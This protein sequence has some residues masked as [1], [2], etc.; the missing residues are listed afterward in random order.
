MFEYG[1]SKW[2]I[3]Y[4][5]SPIATEQIERHKLYEAGGI[6]DIWICGVQNYGTGNKHMEKIMDG[7]FSSKD[8]KFI[9]IHN[10]IRYDLLPIVIY[11]SIDSITYL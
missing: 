5:C 3:E 1:G 2:V 8:N 9:E 10:I 11:L 7:M 6:K 4:Q